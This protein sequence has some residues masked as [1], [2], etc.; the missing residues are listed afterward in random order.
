MKHPL[1]G[2]CTGETPMPPIRYGRDA[3]ATDPSIGTRALF[4]E[5]GTIEPRPEGSEFCAFDGLNH[6]PYGR[7]SLSLG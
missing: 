2:T 5:S 3:H 6:L 1:E 4:D 7:G